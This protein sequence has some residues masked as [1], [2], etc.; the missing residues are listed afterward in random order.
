MDVVG[1]VGWVGYAVSVDISYVQL[2]TELERFKMGDWDLGID[3]D[4][5]VDMHAE[6]V[7]G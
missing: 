3:V 7:A 5:D 6:R 2:G 1:C 4:S